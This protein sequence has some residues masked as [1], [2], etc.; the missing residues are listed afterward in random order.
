M[1]RKALGIALSVLISITALSVGVAAYLKFPGEK[2]ELT[3][4][5][6]GTEEFKGPIYTGSG[7]GYLIEFENG[8][9]FYFAGDTGLLAE[10][11]FVI[12][13]FYKP[14]VAFLPIGG[15]YT[16]GPKEAAY[17][18]TLVN[19][20]YVIPYHYHTFPELT[21]TADEFVDAVNSY[22]DENLTRAQTI[23][24][25]HGA[26]LEIEGIKVTWLGH[27]T[28]LLESVNGS[29]ILID[30]WLEANPDCPT[31]YKNI[32]TFSDID[33]IL[34]THGHIDH[35]T[36]EELDALS[37]MYNPVIIAQ[38][39]LGIYLQDHISVPVALMNIG[40]S[41]TKDSILAQGIVSAEVVNAANLESITITMVEAVHSSSP[42]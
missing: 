9:K 11:K 25:E 31:Q 42:P 7:T 40:G 12:G 34:L 13:D 16:M 27:A 24:L 2:V 30:P 39:E 21:Q 1:D 26:T 36:N 28:M 33:L 22:R 15:V 14:D 18:T 4:P 10:M 6:G 3:P 17:A 29:K 5:P 8:V 37:K 35:I 20:K 32:T 19:P 41:F 23:V 38:W